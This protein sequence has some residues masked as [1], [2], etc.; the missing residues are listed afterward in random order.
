MA[1]IDRKQLNEVKKLISRIIQLPSNRE[2]LNK[3]GFTDA[4]IDNIETVLAMFDIEA[5]SELRRMKEL[6]NYKI[7]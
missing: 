7:K 1:S 3:L 5:N 6:I 2:D 4:E